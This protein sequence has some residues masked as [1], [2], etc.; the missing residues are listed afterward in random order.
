M[1]I[2]RMGR[3]PLEEVGPNREAFESRWRARPRR[4]PRVVQSVQLG[5]PEEWFFGR[6]CAQATS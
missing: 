4:L 2:D 6:S 3:A 1:P 5:E